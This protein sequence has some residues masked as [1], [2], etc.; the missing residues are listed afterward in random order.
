M[1]TEGNTL[2]PVVNEMCSAQFLPTWLHQAR[3]SGAT[4]CA[5]R[6]VELTDQ[7]IAQ[8]AAR[9]RYIF[10][11]EKLQSK[12]N[13]LYSKLRN[14]NDEE[15]EEEEEDSFDIESLTKEI[16]PIRRK[17]NE[18][19]TDL[20]DAVSGMSRTF[21]AGFEKGLLA[22]ER[23][24]AENSGYL[25]GVKKVLELLKGSTDGE[26]GIKLGDKESANLKLLAAQIAKSESEPYVGDNAD[27]L[28]SA[29]E[30]KKVSDELAKEATSMGDSSLMRLAVKDAK[31]SSQAGLL[32]AAESNS[33]DVVK[34]EMETLTKRVSEIRDVS[35]PDTESQEKPILLQVNTTVKIIMR[36]RQ[37]RERQSST[38]TT[39]W[40]SK[41]TRSR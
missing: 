33:P 19:K 38:G 12:Q 24:A 3:G 7:A 34:E 27:A 21:F 32:T 40:S 31:M 37:R 10:L 11:S 17:W 39:K 29:A 41:T 9:R 25:Q 13:E 4:S 8:D 26:V 1:C 28:N 20:L 36:L 14:D 6:G 16:A 23:R 2:G 18:A 5:P 15:D 30:A 35:D 22:G